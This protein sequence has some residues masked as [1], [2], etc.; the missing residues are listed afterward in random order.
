MTESTK[1]GVVGGGA[2]AVC[3][4]DALSQREEAPDA[5]IVFEPS[6]HLW[7]GRA[8]QPD[9][10]SVRVNAPPDDMSVRFGDSRHFEDWLDAR[11]VVV[12]GSRDHVDPWSG[13]RFVPR[14]LY[15]DYL[16]HSARAALRVL[17][18]RGTRVELVRRAVTGARRIPEGVVLRSAAG[19]VEVDY[20]VL[21][22]GGG[23]PADVYGLAGC[24]RFV[25]DP[26]PV[27]SRLTGI[28]PDQDVAVVGSGLTAVDVALSLAARGHRGRISLLSRSG[29]LPAVRQRPVHHVLRHFT[30]GRFRAMAARGQ[31]LTLA[32]AVAVMR[33]ELA[34]AGVSFE[35]VAREVS[36]TGGEDPVARLR[37]QFGAVSDP[38][39]GLRILQRSVPDTGP[40]VWPLLPEADKSTVLRDHYRTIM[41]LCCPMPPSSAAAL[42]SLVDDGRLAVVRGLSGIAPADGG[43]LVTTENGTSRADV[44]VNAVNAPRHRIPPGAEPLLSALVD[45]GAAAR[46]ERG[47]LAVER[48]TSR[49]TVDDQP[50]PR[51]YALGDLAGGSL[52][53]TFGVPSLVDRAFDIAGA[54]GE[55]VARSR[56]AR[57]EAMQTV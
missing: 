29:V 20:T 17:V 26:Y 10:S 27:A 55:H 14:A 25:A 12:G 51:L 3:L 2:S 7:R 37:R 30:P 11:G 41:S 28:A 23:R 6:P 40:D 32:E 13:V 54:I 15:G 34:D 33:A 8:Y 56:L 52:F 24:P 19:E 9:A 4:L 46:H 39:L 16:E 21:C 31:S 18:E 42:L 38:G 44:V 22:V 49:L 50:D 57:G 45:T 5:V 36:A 53:F 48:A 35:A 1:I 47:G 43:F